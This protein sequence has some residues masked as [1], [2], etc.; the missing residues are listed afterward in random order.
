[1]G[2][3]ECMEQLVVTDVQLNIPSS[4]SASSRVEP[5]TDCAGCCE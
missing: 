5:G 2:M 1:M 3:A 4:N